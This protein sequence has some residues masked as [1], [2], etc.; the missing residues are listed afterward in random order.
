M[1]SS[2][3]QIIILSTLLL[4]LHWSQQNIEALPVHDYEVN[5]FPEKSSE[6]PIFSD[7]QYLIKWRRKSPK[8]RKYLR[9]LVLDSNFDNSEPNLELFYPRD[10]Y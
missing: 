5:Q 4:L 9:Q 8:H 6:E 1:A 3:I 2:L 7:H 10:K